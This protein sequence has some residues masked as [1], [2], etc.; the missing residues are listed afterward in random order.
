MQ[1]ASPPVRAR[2]SRGVN[3]TKQEARTA[4][5]SSGSSS[6]KLTA[7]ILPSS[8]HRHSDSFWSMNFD[9]VGQERADSQM[10]AVDDS[11]VQVSVPARR[12]AYER[13]TQTCTEAELRSEWGSVDV[14]RCKPIRATEGT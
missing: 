6:G 4:R 7:I 14:S 8:G 9:G 1:E 5:C 13:C 12:T 3:V 10:L 11:Q 2:E